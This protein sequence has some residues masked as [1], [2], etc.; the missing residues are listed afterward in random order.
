LEEICMAKILLAD[1]SAFMR[2]I[3]TNILAK[4]GQTTIVEA[5][6]GDE[7]VEVYK[8]E[9]PDL[10]LLDI[11][12]KRKYGTESLKEIMQINPQAKVLMVSAVGQEKVIEEAM[13]LGAKGF[14]VKPFKEEEVLN[15]VK[16]IL[17]LG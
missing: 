10:V 17:G 1:D 15:K 14:I 7:A 13:G 9:K 11:V 6:D 5:S 3:L 2:K 8:R 12:M 4:A 16:E